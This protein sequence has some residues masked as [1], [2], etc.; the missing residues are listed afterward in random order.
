VAAP[1]PIQELAAR[2][3]GIPYLY[4]IQR[5]VIS[6]IL[7]GIPQIVVLPTGSGKS[8]CFQLPSLALPGPT[9][10]IIPLL[11]LMA[12]QVRKLTAAKAPVAALRGGMSAAEK[13]DLFRGIRAGAVRI[14][15]A[16]PE[17]CLVPRTE[18]EL[19]ACAFSHLV[20]D[21]AHCISEWGESFRP[22]YRELGAL[23]LRL[24]IPLITAFTATASV[25]VIEKITAM[26]FAGMEVRVVAAAPDR[27]N[28]F[29]RVMPALC[30]LH[31]IVRLLGNRPGPTL[32]FC[33]S[34][35]E[36]ELA[37]RSLAR[38]VPSREVFFYHAGLTALERN[39]VE[40]WFLDSR[41]GMLCATSAYGM[42]VDKPDIRT[43]IHASVPP[44]VEAYLQETGR[45][46]R[47]GE[48]AE[49]IQLVT[50]EDELFLATLS[51]EVERQRYAAMLGYAF[52]RGECRRQ[53]L[54][55]SI[56][57]EASACSGCDVC[58]ASAENEPEGAKE[59]VGFVRRNRRR[60]TPVLAAEILCGARSPRVARGF[61]DSTPGY[62][63][64]HGWKTEDIEEAIAE[65][66]A[67]GALRLLRWGPWVG[68]LS[69]Q[70]APALEPAP[71]A[72]YTFSSLLKY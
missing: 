60:F 18:A 45:A 26:L 1:D 36:T 64:L 65:L 58:D 69:A 54:L 4:P 62:G 38:R 43:V 12:D 41:D 9:L 33:R 8:L 53:L 68:R 6:N 57:Q 44:S 21:E 61:L 25:K 72:C 24:G 3:F 37:A 71:H 34:R 50:R 17:A 48:P 35:K 56:G 28:I 14:V 70:R 15:F 49:A 67:S 39:R 46:G 11:S 22:V 2:E 40:R 52:S 42:G 16:T 63:L 47:D 5:F 55:S 20:V 27:P 10:V 66:V 29:Y 31:V 59:I 32:V 19:A 23:A 13:K 51:G 30:R 7:E